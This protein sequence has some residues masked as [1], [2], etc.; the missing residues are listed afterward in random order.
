MISHLRPRAGIW[1]LDTLVGAL[2]RLGIVPGHIREVVSEG[3]GHIDV[4]PQARG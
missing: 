4:V 2:R 3:D 1:Y